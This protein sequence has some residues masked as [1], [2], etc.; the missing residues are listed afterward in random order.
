MNTAKLADFAEI[1]GTIAI[2]LSLIFVGI[3]V[4]DGNRETRAATIQDAVHSQMDLGTVMA[5]HAATWDKV[6]KGATLNSGPELREAIVIYN[7]FMLDA[8]RRFHQY[9][10]GYLELSLWEGRLRS[11]RRMVALPIYSIWKDSP[12]GTGHSQSFLDIVEDLESA[13]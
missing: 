8:E 6:I 11:L 9:Q 7:L 4:R 5:G 12:G 2:V 1:I 10:S 3:Q 13:D